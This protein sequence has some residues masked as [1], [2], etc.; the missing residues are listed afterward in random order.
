MEGDHTIA[1]CLEATETA[2]RSVF[3]QLAIQNVAL[4]GMILK[5]NMALPGLTCPKQPTADEVAKATVRIL[6][7]VVPVELPGIAFLSGGQGGV[8]A[9]ER[10][11]AMNSRFKS[12][13]AA[14]PWALTF[15]FARAIQQPALEIWAG[16]D[17]NRTAAQDALIHRAKCNRAARMGQYSSSMEAD[18]R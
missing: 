2:L 7:R 4:E 3:Q 16:K 18:G 17:A 6:R 12:P 10:L 13:S 11:N 9:S 1:R 8:L 5:P 14:A 15:S